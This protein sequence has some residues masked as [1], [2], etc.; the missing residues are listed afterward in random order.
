MAED[1]GIQVVVDAKDFQQALRM[2]PIMMKTNLL[3]AGKEIGAKVLMTTGL[4]KYPSATSANRPPT[5]YYIRGQGTQYADR[6]DGRSERYGTQ[7]NTRVQPMRVT[8]GNRASY[9]PYLTDEQRQAKVM[10]V[11]GWR[12][13]I[14]VIREKMAMI[15]GVYNAWIGKAIRQA[16][17]RLK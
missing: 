10:K 2:L 17:F 6:N 15:K 13:L 5:P 11:I 7:W 4:K 1:K 12:T 16:G 3:R 9:A 8:L 14:G